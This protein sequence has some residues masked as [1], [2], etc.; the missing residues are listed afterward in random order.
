M[1]AA[2][3]TA[4]ARTTTHRLRTSKPHSADGH[5]QLSLGRSANSWRAAE[6]RIHRLGTNGIPVSLRPT[7]ATVADLADI[8]RESRGQPG[9]CLDRATGIRDEHGRYRRLR[10][11]RA[12]A[13]LTRPPVRFHSLGIDRFAVAAPIPVSSIVYCTDSASRLHTHTFQLWQRCRRASVVE[14][15][16]AWYGTE[17]SEPCD[18]VSPGQRSAAET[19]APSLWTHQVVH[20][21]GRPT[22]PSLQAVKRK[23]FGDSRKYWRG[24]A[25]APHP[26]ARRSIVASPSRPSP[27]KSGPRATAS[28]SGSERG[29]DGL[30]QLRRRPGADVQA[31]AAAQDDFDHGRARVAGHVHRHERRR[32][33]ARL[34]GRCLVRQFAAPIPERPSRNVMTPSKARLR[35][36][37]LAPPGH[38]ARHAR[39]RRFGHHR[40]S[41]GTRIGDRQATLKTV[42]RRTLSAPG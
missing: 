30:H 27:D 31:L 39:R 41:S 36:P 3:R 23:H 17:I 12:H 15:A 28:A 13:A 42:V 25:H 19:Q 38:E 14:P 6:A 33:S 10:A 18:S 29:H 16:L 5:R 4:T 26:P 35:L 11:V 1:L 37:T 24:T 22:P 34:E 2:S 32:R 21:G 9:L 40:Q 20:I 7:D 8:P